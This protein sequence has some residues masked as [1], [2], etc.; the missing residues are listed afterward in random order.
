MKVDLLKIKSVLIGIA[1]GDALGMPTEFLTREQ[2]AKLYPKGVNTFYPSNKYDFIGRQF[3]AGRVT[4]DT[5]NSMLLLDN[6][7]KNKKAVKTSDYINSLINWK[8]TMPDANLVMGPSSLKALSAI[9]KGADLLETGKYA[10]TNGSM[11]KIA[12]IGI[13]YDYH[14]LDKLIE[15]V[16]KVC[17]PTHGTNVA[18]TGSAI[19]AALVSYGIYNDSVSSIDDYWNL[20]GE[21]IAKS[22]DYGNKVPC[23]SLRK[24]IDHMKK[25]LVSHNQKE[26]LDYLYDFIGCGVNV[27]ETV[28]T[29]LTIIT[30]ANLD[31][32]RAAKIA[33]NLGGD[34]DTNASICAAI[35]GGVKPIF[36][37]ED[38]EFLKKVNHYDFEGL[39]KEVAE[40]I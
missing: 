12:P 4:D 10:M 7:I 17:Y 6:L 35:C 19:V 27:I 21:V 16:Y 9:E 31:P 15:A 39:A 37:T 14:D 34:T 38:I 8:N 30:L 28:P 26:I 40:I 3:T 5:I 33:A 36:K 32:Y 24:R 20:A 22:K 25:Y 1:Y 23:P 18:I 2:I 11:M 29:I 13:F